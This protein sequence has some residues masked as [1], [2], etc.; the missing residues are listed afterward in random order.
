MDSD[1][2]PYI[3]ID[4]PDGK[5]L[6][7]N[8]TINITYYYVDSDGKMNILNLGGKTVFDYTFSIKNK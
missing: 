7:E 3:A 2:Y 8:N 5:E 1:K 4:I 6:G